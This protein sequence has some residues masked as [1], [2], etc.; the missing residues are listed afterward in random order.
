MVSPPTLNMDNNNAFSTPADFSRTAPPGKFRLTGYDMYD[1]S[2]YRVADF[3]SMAE[4]REEAVARAAEPNGDP[5]SF[6]DN[7]LVYDEHGNCLLTVKSSESGPVET[8]MYSAAV[9]SSSIPENEAVDSPVLHWS[10]SVIEDCRTIMKKFLTWRNLFTAFLLWLPALGF[11]EI[12]AGLNEG[13]NHF[14]H[15]V[16][17]VET[18]SSREVQAHPMARGWGN[19]KETVWYLTYH[20]TDHNGHIRHDGK[21]LYR[22]EVPA[23]IKDLKPGEQLYLRVAV[24][25]SEG[26]FGLNHRSDQGLGVFLAFGAMALPIILL[27]HAK[28]SPKRKQLAERI[29][30]AI[31]LLSIAFLVLN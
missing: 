27:I 7:F 16:V 12:I 9:E 22:D 26:S 14:A 13:P 5:V 18:L 23:Y 1:Y 21:P 29:I 15:R 30:I 24:D 6:S 3:D 17:V 28:D 4:A 20:Y 19:V 11:W 8:W 25:E 2:D 31:F 10:V